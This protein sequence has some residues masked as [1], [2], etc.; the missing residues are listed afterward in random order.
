MKFQRYIKKKYKSLIPKIK[1]LSQHFKCS[2]YTNFD[3]F[4]NLMLL[5]VDE[6]LSSCLNGKIFNLRHYYC[7]TFSYL[8][9]SK[10]ILQ[11]LIS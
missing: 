1:I 7:V 5:S 8:P 9:I 6:V 2:F 11:L 3:K 10:F 4:D